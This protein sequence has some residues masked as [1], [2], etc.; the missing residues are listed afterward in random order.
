MALVVLAGLVLMSATAL[1]RS[2]ALAATGHKFLSQLSEAPPGTPLGAPEGVAVDKAGDVFVAD[3]AA[4]VVD[5][6]DS[7]GAFKAQLGS[8]TAVAGLLASSKTILCV[9]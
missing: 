1:S 2:S 6:F 4:G 5:V 3:A 9:L 8:G 7:G